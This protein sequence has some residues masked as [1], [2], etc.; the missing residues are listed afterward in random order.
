M[1]YWSSLWKSLERMGPDYR[2]AYWER[3]IQNERWA[4]Q[5]NSKARKRFRMPRPY[6]R[7]LHMSD[8]LGTDLRT[9]LRRL[10]H[11]K[12]RSQRP[13]PLSE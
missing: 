6:V 9:M 11:C 4:A 10:G 8:S 1:R 12:R 2:A 5:A 3:T 7:R 13:T